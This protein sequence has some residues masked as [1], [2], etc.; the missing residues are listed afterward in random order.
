VHIL[1]FGASIALLD[2]RIL[3]PAVIVMQS[4]D[5]NA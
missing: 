4:S 3:H 2:L 1:D 5:T